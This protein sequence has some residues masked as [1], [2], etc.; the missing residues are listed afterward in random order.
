M[1]VIKANVQENYVV[2]TNSTAQDERL[3][4]EARGMVLL[5]GSRPQGWKF[6]KTELMSNASIGRDKLNR[7]F[8]EL[9]NY[10]YL[11]IVQNHDDQ[12]RF[13]DAD[14]HFFTDPT[15]NPA[16]YDVAPCTEKPYTAKPCNGK[17]AP[18]KERVFIKERSLENGRT[19][20]IDRAFEFFWEYY[21]KKVAKVKAKSAFKALM[22]GK[23]EQK[24]TDTTELA[25]NYMVEALEKLKAGNDNFLGYDNMN[26]STYLNQKRWEDQ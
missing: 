21:P 12:G 25:V 2:V 5:M 26:A 13:I 15:Q 3:S 18:I 16:F 8:K 7:L 19:E 10:G 4:L 24:I 14:Y 23:S 11:A 20:V 1:A 9:A 6:N 17:S 22:K